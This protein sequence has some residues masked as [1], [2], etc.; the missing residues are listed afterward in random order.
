MVFIPMHIPRIVIAGTHS[1][2]GKT[3]VTL[4]VLRALRR[5]GLVVQPFKAGP[6]FIDPSLHSV[7]TGRVSR[8]LDLWLLPR[9]TV[10]ELC[11]RA[12]EGSDIAVIEGV[13]GLFDGYHGGGEEGS[14]AEIAK[15][16]AAPVVLVVDAAGAVRSIAATAMGFSAFDPDLTIAGV[17]ANRVGSDRH[18]AWLQDALSAAGIPLLGT[19]PWDERL[20]LPER[21]LGLVPAQEQ[22]AEGAIAALG[23]AVEA[24]VDLDRILRI[25][26]Q[27]P[28]LVV[29][30]P[31]VFPLMTIPADVRIGV[32]RDAAFHFYYPDALDLLESR[33]ANVI[34]FSPIADQSIPDVDGLYLGGGFPEVY[35]EQLS[36]NRSMQ[37][38]VLKAIDRGMPIYAECG[39]LMY[40]CRDIIDQNGTRHEMVGAVAATAQ[41][42]A[43]LVALAYVTLEADEDT[44]LLRKG[45]QVRGHEFHFS[46]ISL[47][48]PEPLVLRS[49]EGR[50]IDGGRDGIARGNL[51]ATFTHL[52]FAGAPVLAER[53]VEACRRFK[54]EGG[55]RAP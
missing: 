38:S 8:T 15:W 4:G 50:G 20:V 6:D 29:P 45:E 28:P 36:A 32:A 9:S 39:G 26:R 22:S 12:A 43:R 55:I 48:E 14:T 53:F 2:S 30:G 51:L 54:N 44:L 34:P 7:A 18:T 46:S 42:H 21:H 25:A 52:H 16:L 27:A 5:R 41:T 1:G 3:S 47:D 35:A 13:M 19:L 11:A 31:L 37:D 24:H 33:G 23:E 49:R 10:I 17:I 40:L